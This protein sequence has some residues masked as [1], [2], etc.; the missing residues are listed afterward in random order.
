[1]SS[2][3]FDVQCT[4]GDNGEHTVEAES[5]EEASA[6]ISSQYPDASISHDGDD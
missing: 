1:M 3:T 5:L 6:D 2:Y 4:D